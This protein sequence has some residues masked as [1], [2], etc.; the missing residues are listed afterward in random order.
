MQTT[1]PVVRR[2]DALCARVNAGLTVFTV[3]LAIVVVVVACVQRLPEIASLFQ[4]IDPGT[5]ISMLAY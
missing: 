2:L 1:S 3:L 5:G 4:P